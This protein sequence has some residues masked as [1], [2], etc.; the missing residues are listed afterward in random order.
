MKKIDDILNDVTLNND[1]TL[2]VSNGINEDFIKISE[3]S[4]KKNALSI[5]KK[6]YEIFEVD[7]LENYEISFDE[8]EDIL[9]NDEIKKEISIKNIKIIDFLKKLLHN[10]VFLIDF[11][12][13][14]IYALLEVEEKKYI[15]YLESKL[16]KFSL[17]AFFV[18]LILKNKQK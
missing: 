2:V 10:Y 15:I 5:D 3:A 16:D 11:K 18:K 14:K 8:I 7:F 9:E 4:F 1:K 12:N 13:K 17:I 6:V